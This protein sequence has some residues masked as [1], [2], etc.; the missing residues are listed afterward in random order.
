MTP[1]Y[2]AAETGRIKVLKYFV[3][4]QADI[5]IQDDQGVIMYYINHGKEVYMANLQPEDQGRG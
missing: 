3:D 5:N 4:Q 2:L 1:S